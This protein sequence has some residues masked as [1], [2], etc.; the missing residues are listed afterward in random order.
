MAANLS[1]I[2]QTPNE[3]D[4]VDNE[5]SIA[6]YIPKSWFKDGDKRVNL[7]LIDLN[8]KTIWGG[9]ISVDFPS[10]K[11]AKLLSRYHFQTTFRIHWANIP[12]IKKSCGRVALKLSGMEDRS[13]L[14]CIPIIV[15]EYEPEGG[16]DESINILHKSIGDRLVRYLTESKEYHRELLK[17]ETENATKI[18][19]LENKYKDVVEWLGERCGGSVGGPYRGFKFQVHSNDHGIHFHA[20]H[21]GRCIDARFSFDE[22]KGVQ[23]LNYV[24]KNHMKSKE[25]KDIIKRFNNPNNLKNLKD[26]FYKRC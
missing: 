13:Q 19:E 22:S 23:F 9:D 7:E 11:L 25:V 6:G 26:E 2:I 10:I 18:A 17:I 4:I 20:I 8:C 15:N 3:F 24:S 14:I 5:F 21:K 1:V 12:F 16:V